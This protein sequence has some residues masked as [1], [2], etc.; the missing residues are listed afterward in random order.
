MH[1][2]RCSCCNIRP[3]AGARLHCRCCNIRPVKV[4]VGRNDDD[5]DDNNNS[6][7]II[8][9]LLLY[10]TL[11]RSKWEYSSTVCINITTTIADKQEHNQQNYTA[12]YCSLFFS[13]YHNTVFHISAAA[14][15]CVTNHKA[16][17][18]CF[19]L[20]SFYFRVKILSSIILVS[21]FVI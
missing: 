10:Y 16:S 8:L 7:L 2:L 17:P 18:W 6:L 5:D 20:Y 19:F 1:A 11:D 15:T 13:S 14:V 21:V 3:T 12:L 9:L 4:N